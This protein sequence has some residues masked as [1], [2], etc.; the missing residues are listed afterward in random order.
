M[1]PDPP[2]S[3][4]LDE[5]AVVGQSHSTMAH[6]DWFRSDTWDKP[7]RQ[8][9][10]ATLARA[11]TPFQ[12][13]QYLRIQGVTLVATNKRREVI[14][15]RTLLDRVIADYP[16]ELLEVAGA[17]FALAE[18]LLGDNQ[19]NE[20]IRHLRICLILES[21]RSFKHGT[22]LTLAEALLANDS[23]SES[24]DE[25]EHLL[26]KAAGNSFFRS[27]AWRVTV[28]RARLHAQRGDAQ[29]AATQAEHALALLADN[30]PTL[31]RHPDVGLI[32]ANQTT[33]NEMRKL[34]QRPRG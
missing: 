31:S 25:A 1:T 8:A 10:E 28:A 29:A 18:S 14:A 12:R 21:G 16:D 4:R 6:D 13:A 30:T 24:L 19:P 34:A 20:G 15:G 2:R 17:H 23:T 27:E 3:G 5:F 33:V 22:E 26:D 11:R 7:T 9:F 32:T